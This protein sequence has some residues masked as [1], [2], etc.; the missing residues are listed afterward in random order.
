MIPCIDE[1]PTIFFSLFTI[2][3]GIVLPK[4]THEE[5]FLAWMVYGIVLTTQFIPL[6]PIKPTFSDGF[7]W[8]SDGVPFVR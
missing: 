2:V 7:R 5:I 6:N 3:Y 4:K 8:L 1:I